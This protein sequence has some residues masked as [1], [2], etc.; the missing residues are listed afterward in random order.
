MRREALL[1]DNVSKVPYSLTLQCTQTP[2]S[3]ELLTPPKNTQHTHTYRLMNNS[4]GQNS[5]TRA[6]PSTFNG[7]IYIFIAA[8]TEVPC[9]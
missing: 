6:L 3:K 5:S 1:S 8:L 4:S 2:V 7:G 9:S